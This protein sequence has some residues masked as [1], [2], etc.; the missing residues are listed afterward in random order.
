MKLRY[1]LKDTESTCGAQIQIH[2]YLTL[3]GGPQSQ[4]SAFSYGLQGLVQFR[5]PSSPKVNEDSLNGPVVSVLWHNKRNK[6]IVEFKQISRY[7]V[8]S[9][10]NCIYK[11]QIFLEISS[12]YLSFSVFFLQKEDSSI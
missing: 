1:F 2:T 12:L 10:V 6:R 3:K 5:S 7:S 11:V 4:C 8:S 9:S